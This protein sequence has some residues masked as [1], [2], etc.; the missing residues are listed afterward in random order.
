MIDAT[1][2]TATVV[3]FE[4]EGLRSVYAFADT[5]VLDVEHIALWLGVSSDVAADLPIKWIP[6]GRGKHRFRRRAFAKHVVEYLDKE[7]K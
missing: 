6:L 7:A 5:A 3:H 1:E 2:L 4:R